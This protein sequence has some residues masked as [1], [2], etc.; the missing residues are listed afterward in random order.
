[1]K[2]GLDPD[3]GTSSSYP[4]NIKVMNFAAPWNNTCS[5]VGR[6][7]R[8]GNVN[9]LKELLKENKPVDVADNR[10]WRPLHEAVASSIECLTVLLKHGGSDINWTSH[11][12][13]T[14]LLLACKR[15]EGSVASAF[16]SLLLEHGA[17]PN[18]LDNEQDS[19]LL[20]AIRH[21]NRYVVQQL[22][23]AGAN[24]NSAD[25]SKWTPLHEAAT[26]QDTAILELLLS[27]NAAIDVQ[28]EC[29]I[30]PIFT[31][32]QH[33]F[34]NC[35]KKLISAAKERN[36]KD[37]IDMGAE[38]WAT[39]LMIAAQQGFVDCVKILL[40]AGADPDLKTSD[41]ATALHLAVQ[42]DNKLCAEILM[43]KMK[44][45]PLIRKFHPST[46]VGTDMICPLHLA[47]EW[48]SYGSLQALIAGGFSPDSLYHYKKSIAVLLGAG[49]STNPPSRESSH[50]VA[51]AMLNPEPDI[52]NILIAAG[53]NIN[54]QRREGHTNEIFLYSLLTSK[55]YMKLL[56]YH[57]Y[58]VNICFLAESEIF[59]FIRC[60]ATFLR[61]EK[62]PLCEFSNL[63]LKFLI[64]TKKV[65]DAFIKLNR[66]F[67]EDITDVINKMDQPTS[68]MQMCS[69]KIRQHLYSI[70]GVNLPCAIQ[71]LDLPC[72]MKD[73]LSCRNDLM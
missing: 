48:K 47:V 66:Q 16:V 63:M 43:D 28:D 42:G 36:R 59:Y 40:E 33:G 53:T 3:Q 46:Y 18:I 7:A 44:L 26:K 6:V 55:T 50:P 64:N 58:D 27:K 4:R 37:I 13:E 8:H 29:G 30:T 67:E 51:K 65:Q 23:S 24:V 10:G 61:R 22:I 20:A 1:M 32:A 57:G 49:A 39:P 34:E 54:H 41:N 38:D 31:A 62:I 35:L 17:D 14:A 70:H 56:L 45:H 5:T 2:R 19:P 60:A 52:F 15:H 9:L 12:G 71:N 25:F 21:K 11:E 69:I 73:F 72:L 68:M